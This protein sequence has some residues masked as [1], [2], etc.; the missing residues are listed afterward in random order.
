MGW[1]MP[2]FISWLRMR[3]KNFSCAETVRL[4]TK[5][6]KWRWC[7][8]HLQAGRSRMH[9][10]KKCPRQRWFAALHIY[11]IR[12][13]TDWVRDL[14]WTC[15][16]LQSRWQGISGPC[17]CACV[18]LCRVKYVIQFA[19]DAL[20]ALAFADNEKT[21][22]LNAN[23]SSCHCLDFFIQ[24]NDSSSLTTA[25]TKEESIWMCVCLLWITFYL[26]FKSKQNG[27]SAIPF[28]H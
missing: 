17:L 24:C 10:L 18:C 7:L 20:N 6:W 26:L 4:Q 19:T 5:Q 3:S 9:F 14:E 27:S 13:T 16:C 22:S 8:H 11:R 12:E 28:R 25:R 23:K 1:K 21:F 2:Q 15:E